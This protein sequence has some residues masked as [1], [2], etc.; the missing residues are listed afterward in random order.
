MSQNLFLLK[1]HQSTKKAADNNLELKY[2]V[3]LV[4]VLCDIRST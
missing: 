2:C 3:T 1:E 4:D